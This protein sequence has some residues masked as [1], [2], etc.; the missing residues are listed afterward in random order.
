VFHSLRFITHSFSAL[1][2]GNLDSVKRLLD[3]LTGDNPLDGSAVSDLMVLQNDAGETA[4][5][6]AVENNLQ[7]LFRFLLRFVDIQT[8]MIRSK[9]DMDVFLVAAK[10]GHLVILLKLLLCFGF[11]V[12]MSGIF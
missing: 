10:H 11:H 3:E 12:T 6:M 1:R 9:S 5:Y 7:D 4:L 2:S 8:L